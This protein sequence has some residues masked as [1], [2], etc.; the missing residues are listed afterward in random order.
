LG[1]NE[2]SLATINK[3]IHLN[4]ATPMYYFLEQGRVYENRGQ[5]EGAIAAYKKALILNPNYLYALY[6]L[7]VVT[8]I[9]DNTIT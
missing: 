1:R 4:P 6:R 5:Y 7:D 9:S 2:G 3:A 8:H